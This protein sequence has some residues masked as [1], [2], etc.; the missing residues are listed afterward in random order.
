MRREGNQRGRSKSEIR[1]EKKDLVETNGVE[2]QAEVEKA[3]GNSIKHSKHDDCL[4]IYGFAFEEIQ[5]LS[6]VKTAV[7]HH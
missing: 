1:R 2:T 5:F 4:H 6:Y 3:N 7:R